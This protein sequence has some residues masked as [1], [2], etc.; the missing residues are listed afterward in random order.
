M[1][2]LAVLGGIAATSWLTIKIHHYKYHR[3]HWVKGINEKSHE[4]VFMTFDQWKTYYNAD[5]DHWQEGEFEIS[6]VSAPL[7]RTKKKDYQV[8]FLTIFDYYRFINFCN[9]LEKTGSDAQNVKDMLEL[10]EIIQKEAAARAE[11][12]RKES[13]EAFDKMVAA[14]E[15]A[16]EGARKGTQTWPR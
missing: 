4:D 3:R 12:A 6:S 15:R 13:Q 7:Y 5:P 9:K 1:M 16:M 10:T 11:K 8:S 14:Q 2:W